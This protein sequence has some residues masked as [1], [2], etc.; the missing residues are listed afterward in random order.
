MSDIYYW[1]YE[2]KK[3]YCLCGSC[4]YKWSFLF[5]RWETT[6]DEYSNTLKELTEEEAQ[7]LLDNYYMIEELKK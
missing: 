7:K 4:Y 3:L 5:K 2:I 1:D 6:W